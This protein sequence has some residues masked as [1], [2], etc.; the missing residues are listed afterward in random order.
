MTHLDL[1]V[2]FAKISF[3]PKLPR[4][5]VNSNSAPRFSKSA[6][7]RRFECK[8]SLKPSKKQEISPKLFQKLQQPSFKT[9]FPKF[10]K[11]PAQKTPH[12]LS[13]SETVNYPNCPVRLF[14]TCLLEDHVEFL[15][16]EFSVSI[17]V[18]AIEND[19]VCVVWDFLSH[20]LE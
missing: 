14:W 6:A 19:F 17:F 13:K 2:K 11:F 1:N 4:K 9:K 18:D 15:F 3:K 20:L 12:Y 5:S 8:N 16:R 10:P 7:N